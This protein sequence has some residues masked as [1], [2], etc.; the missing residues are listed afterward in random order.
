MLENIDLRNQCL[1]Q[2]LLSNCQVYRSGQITMKHCTPVLN[3]VNDFETPIWVRKH[4]L[5]N[6]YNG[7]NLLVNKIYN[8][9]LLKG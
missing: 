3:D 1:A 7:A 2:G 6:G 4:A 5:K 9:R 8:R